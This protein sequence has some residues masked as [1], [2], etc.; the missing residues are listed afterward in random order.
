MKLENQSVSNLKKTKGNLKAR[1][2]FNQVVKY[3]FYSNAK[4]FLTPP[5]QL[6]RSRDSG[7]P[8]APLSS[9]WSTA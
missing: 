5:T 2:N 8:P 4:Q 1:A 6:N 7:R 9:A 3:K